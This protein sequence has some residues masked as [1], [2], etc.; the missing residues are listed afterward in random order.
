[1]LSLAAAGEVRFQEYGVAGEG[2]V[3]LRFAQDGLL[4]TVPPSAQPQKFTITAPGRW[5]VSGA[6]LEE[7][8]DASLI[9][10]IPP[11]TISVRLTRK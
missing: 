1:M 6:Q 5:S 8:K 10:S 4:V 11:G 9:L 7:T 3:S 2:A